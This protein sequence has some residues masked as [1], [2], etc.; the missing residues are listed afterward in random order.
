MCWRMSLGRGE[1]YLACLQLQCDMV[2]LQV[3]KINAHQLLQP[4]ILPSLLAWQ[5][6]L[7]WQWLPSEVRNLAVQGET[8]DPVFPC[9]WASGSR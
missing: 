2:A 5:K 4:F 9:S 3:A 6:D 8:D 7:S 1:V